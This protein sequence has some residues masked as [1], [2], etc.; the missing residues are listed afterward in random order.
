METRHD[1]AQSEQDTMLGF[2]PFKPKQL[3]VGQI[4]ATEHVQHLSFLYDVFF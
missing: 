1:T 2:K 4:M 3:Q